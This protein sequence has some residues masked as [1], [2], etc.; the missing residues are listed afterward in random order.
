M[1]LSVTPAF[2]WRDVL[3]GAT[4]RWHIWVEDSENEHIYHTEVW[5]LTKKMMREGTHRIAFTIPVFEPLPSQYF[6]RC[7][8]SRAEAKPPCFVVM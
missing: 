1:Q 5:L 4:M 3:H 6:V 7:V 2:E 8:V